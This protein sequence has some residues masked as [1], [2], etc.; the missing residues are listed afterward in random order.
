MTLAAWCPYR[1]A[2][3]GCQLRKRKVK[4]RE[5]DGGIEEKM[6]ADRP[7]CCCNSDPRC[8]ALPCTRHAIGILRA[9][10]SARLGLP[11]GFGRAQN[12]RSIDA[13]VWPYP[14]A[15]CTH[16]QSLTPLRMESRPR[17]LSGGSGAR[18][19]RKPASAF[20]CSLLCSSALCLFQACP[21]AFTHTSVPVHTA[22]THTRT[23]TQ[24]HP[25]VRAYLSGCTPTNYMYRRPEL[26]GIREC[27]RPRQGSTCLSA[28]PRR[29]P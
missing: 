8:S 9:S 3:V 25:C 19:R 15:G 1:Q 18:A 4:S 28:L 17:W 21:S 5:A 29:A 10:Q 7:L 6:V 11:G 22:C 24:T 13:S 14:A 2:S 23:R 26:P 20:E 16:G 12:R 27:G